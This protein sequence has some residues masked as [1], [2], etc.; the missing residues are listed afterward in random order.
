[1]TFTAITRAH[2]SSVVSRFI[3]TTKPWIN[4]VTSAPIMWAPSSCPVLASKMV[5]TSAASPASISAAQTASARQESGM[6]GNMVAPPRCWSD[7]GLGD[8]RGRCESTCKATA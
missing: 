6:E 7:P 5:L 1:M 2:S 3:A 8:S 4:S